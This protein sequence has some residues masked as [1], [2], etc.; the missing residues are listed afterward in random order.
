MTALV[1]V[2]LYLLVLTVATA[3]AR[4]GTQGSPVAMTERGSAVLVWLEHNP[5]PGTPRS[6]RAVENHFRY[7]VWR[8]LKLAGVA[9]LDRRTGDVDPRSPFGCL[10]QHEGRWTSNT[11]NGYWGGL[12][13]DSGF[14]H[15]Y[16]AEYVQLWGYPSSWPVW[17]QVVAAYRAHHGYHGYG[18]RGY[19]PWGTRGMCG[20]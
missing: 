10:H 14:F 16:G 6:R 7:L 11:G 2:A 3:T 4:G 15:T 13:F 5:K 9:W 12:Q 1:L 8:G 18:A 19:A 17:S 20:L